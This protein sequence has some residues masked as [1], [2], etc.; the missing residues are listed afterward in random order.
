VVES[1]T[2]KTLLEALELRKNQ[3]LIPLAGGTDLMVRKR[4]WA[5]TLPRFE[6]PALFIGG[7]A[8]LKGI[9]AKGGILTIGGAATLASILE[10][11]EVPDILKQAVSLMASPA[12]RN[13]GTLAGNICNAS[14]AA[15]TLPPLYA[16]GAVLMLQN[17]AGGREL[18][19]A[20]FIKG[21]GQTDLKTDELLATVKIPIQSYDVVFYKKVAARKADA[22]S[23]VSF[24][25][26][27]KVSGDM[28]ADI[29]IA[30]GA[31][32][33]RVVRSMEAE[34]LLKGRKIR[35]LAGLIPELKKIYDPLIKPIND[36]RSDA[37]YRSQ[38]AHRLI[39]YYITQCASATAY[40]K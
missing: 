19:I 37:V 15:D 30:I 28:V 4:S 35:D 26:L 20:E 27:A 6:Y 24:T 12:I 23:K 32:A 25:G 10:H 2:P 17:T 34:E 36:Q 29:Q 38:V 13:A 8:E 14:P 40:A 22:L 21:P 16:L 9:N 7:L 39:E 1:L 33:P 18:P 31:V 11:P 3:R 5:G